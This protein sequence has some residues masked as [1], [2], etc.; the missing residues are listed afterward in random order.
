[1]QSLR[2]SLRVDAFEPRD[3]TD[4]VVTLR[5]LGMGILN[6][7]LNEESAGENSKFARCAPAILNSLV[8]PTGEHGVSNME[9]LVSLAAKAVS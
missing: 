7:L 3:T 4:T 5:R 1:M 8:L 6:R 2:A 9:E